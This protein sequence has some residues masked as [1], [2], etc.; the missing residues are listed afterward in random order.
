M[1][2]EEVGG[3]FGIPPPKINM[4]VESIILYVVIILVIGGEGGILKKVLDIIK[5]IKNM[6]DTLDSISEKNSN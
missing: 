5:N 4:E 3:D 2:P 1:V 6:E